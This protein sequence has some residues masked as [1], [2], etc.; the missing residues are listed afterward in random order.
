M[1]WLTKHNILRGIFTVICLSGLT[2]CGG[3]GAQYNKVEMATNYQVHKALKINVLSF[4][5]LSDN[6]E[7]PKLSPVPEGYK[8]IAIRLIV[9]NPG[10]NRGLES[11]NFARIIDKVE[12]YNP[13][14]NKPFPI[15]KNSMFENLADFRAGDRGIAYAELKP[16]ESKTAWILGTIAKDANPPFTLKLTPSKRVGT[17][18]AME[19]NLNSF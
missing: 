11:S 9:T 15:N 3:G 10:E 13:G 16:G 14:Y 5:S 8:Y 19:V 4:K 18:R 17:V 12:L 2:S 1:Q 7:V 6:R